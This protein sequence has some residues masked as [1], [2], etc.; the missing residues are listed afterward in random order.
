MESFK[1][2]VTQELFVEFA[3]QSFDG[4]AEHMAANGI[5]PQKL[6]SASKDE[7]LDI[8]KKL[9]PDTPIYLTPM[10]DN[11][12]GGDKGSS[13]GEDGIRITG[14]WAFIGSILGRLK[15]LL[16]YEN[17]QSKLRLVFRGI[18]STRLANPEKQAYAFYVNLERRS[19]GKPGRPK[20]PQAPK[21]PKP[22]I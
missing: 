9:R 5:N 3:T 15:E 19:P 16:Q 22:V 13:Y 8:W 2:F 4:G 1:D 11:D 20:K 10:D 14:S 12:Q 7:I 17:P 18:D 6:W 21:P